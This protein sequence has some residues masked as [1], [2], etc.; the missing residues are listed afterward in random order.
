MSK[1]D[2]QVGD[3]WQRALDSL[4]AA[5]KLLEEG[6]ADFAA[7]RAYYAAFYAA[8]ALLLLEGKR[9]SKHRGVL[10][11]IHKDYVREGRL[12]RQMGRIINSLFELRAVGDYGGSV[13]VEAPAAETGVAN[14]KLFL[15]AVRPLLSQHLDEQD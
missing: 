5:E 3:F 12:P 1:G 8:C 15:E 11:Q 10:A 7:S 4:K 2:P 6:F 9:F 13:H 14:A